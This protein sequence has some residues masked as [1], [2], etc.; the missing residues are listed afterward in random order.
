MNNR[1]TYFEKIV[2]IVGPDKSGKTTLQEKLIQNHKMKRIVSTTTRAPREGEVDG[3]DYR[4]I[5]SQ[6]FLQRKDNNEFLQTVEYGGTH[7][8][9]RLTE[10]EADFKGQIGLFVCTPEG[11]NDTINALSEKFPERNIKYGVVFL[12]PSDK[13]LDSR[14]RDSLRGNRG[15]LR[16]KYLEME[17]LGLFD[18]TVD[19]TLTLNDND[20]SGAVISST[21]LAENVAH[22][23]QG[24]LEDQERTPLWYYCTLSFLAGV[25]FA[26]SFLGK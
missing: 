6:E 26:I 22:E 23:L 21:E 25:L 20:I 16:G 4:F 17:S 10:Y 5:Q 8:G 18:D 11:I 19:I 9:T 13:L 24:S 7:Y 2:F 14:G 12:N 15:D 3:V 1:R